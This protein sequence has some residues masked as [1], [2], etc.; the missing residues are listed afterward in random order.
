MTLLGHPNELPAAWDAV[1][2]E[3]LVAAMGCAIERARFAAQPL[4]RALHAFGLTDRNT[5]AHFI[6]QVGHQTDS[7]VTVEAVWEPTLAQRRHERSYTTRWTARDP[8]NHEAFRLGNHRAG[9]GKLYRARGWLP[10]LGRHDY[11]RTT[12]HL[13][14]KFEDTPDFGQ[15][16]QMLALPKWAAL[17]AADRWSWAGLNQL[18][19]GYDVDAVAERL[20]HAYD[21]SGGLQARLVRASRAAQDLPDF[22][23]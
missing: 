16:P 23:P 10:V 3:W 17:A 8:I 19:H 7:L 9:D 5:I 11:D 14:R 21:H 22:L 13:Q 20:G 12:W 2:P 1:S 15:Y 6:T 4:A 18:V